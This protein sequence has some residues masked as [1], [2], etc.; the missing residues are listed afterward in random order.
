ML[1]KNNR[2]CF[3]VDIKT[4]IVKSSQPCNWG[5][6]YYSVIGFGKAHFW[7]DNNDKKD[8]LDVIMTKYSPQAS[9]EF[10]PEDLERVTVIK[11]EID[12]LTGKKSGY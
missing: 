4:E 6:R 7:N 3:E 8:A 11:V 10:S 1:R 5:M 2:V 9:F 12:N